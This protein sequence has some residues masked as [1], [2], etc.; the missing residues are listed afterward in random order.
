MK[1]IAFVFLSLFSVV[2]ALA[3]A[4]GGSISGVIKDPQGA[5]IPAVQLTLVNT[6]LKTEFK[7]ASDNQGFYSFP[8]L[9]VGH[10]DLTAALTGFEAQK[11]SNIAV[12]ADAAASIS[13]SRFKP[14]PNPSR[15]K[16]PKPTC[17][18]KSTPS[19]RTL[20]KSSATRKFRPFRSTAAATPIC[21][22]SSRESLPS[23]R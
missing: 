14:N 21:S 6:A 17:K 15:S 12:D 2:S 4:G 13:L 5:V 18:P 7:A 22:P 9:P 1:P 3:A 23:P 8:A 20:A 19:R 10:Y 16:K 11:K